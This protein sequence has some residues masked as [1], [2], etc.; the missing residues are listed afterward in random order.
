METPVTLVDELGSLA[1]TGTLATSSL[2]QVLE[3]ISNTISAS[4]VPNATTAISTLEAMA[5]SLSKNYG[6]KK[7]TDM[8]IRSLKIAKEQSKLTTSM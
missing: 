4:S 5:L 6:E 8:L 3:R 1:A 7:A 2:K